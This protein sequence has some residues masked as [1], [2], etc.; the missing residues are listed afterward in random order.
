MANPTG[1]V[2]TDSMNTTQAHHN[3]S[4]SR[5]SDSLSYRK[6][7]TARFGEY[8][9]SFEME[10]VPTDRISLNSSDKMDSM[11]LKAP[12]K[13]TIR[14]IKESFS[15][16]NMA[17]L[18]QNWDR[19]YTQPSNG[20]DVP[21]DANCVLGN[22]PRNNQRFWL[23][24]YN[25]VNGAINALTSSSTLAD[26]AALL[27]GVF[28]CLF[29]G[30]YIYSYG[31]LPHLM[32]YKI[33][34]EWHYTRGGSSGFNGM[35][36]DAW[37][38]EVIR[39]FV[40]GR[41]LQFTL[42]EPV[43]SSFRSYLINASAS[44]EP[45]T[46][47]YL[48][49][50]RFFIEKMRE[51]P[52][53]YISDVRLNN[54]TTLEQYISVVQKQIDLTET[55][56]LFGT[57]CVFFYDPDAREDTGDITGMS[58]NN[59]NISRILAYQLVCAHY[60]SNSSIDFIYSAEL[61][62]QYVHTF[63][64]NQYATPSSSVERSFVWNGMNCPYDY[65]SEHY[66][67]RSLYMKLSALDYLSPS[68][69]SQPSFADFTDTSSSNYVA[70]MNRLA[71]Y[72]AIF[73]FRKSLRFGDYFVGSR[74]RPLAPINTDVSVNNNLVSV[75]D[76]TRNIQAQRFANA[77]IRSRQKIEEYVKSMFGNS[78]AP[79][80]HNPFFLSRETEVIF[81]DEVQNTG[82]A[83]AQNAVSRTALWASQ[84]NR[85]TFTFENDDAHP[86][87]YLQIVSFDV[88]RSYTRSVDRQF[89]NADRYD[90]FNPDFQYIGDQ[91][92]YGIELGYPLGSSLPYVFGYQSRDMEYKQR[93]DVAS[94]GFVENLP[95][96]LLTDRTRD[97]I[98]IAQLDPDF[99]RSFSC[100]LD[101]FY[102]SLTGYSLGSYFH[103]AIITDNNV[104]AVRP[105]A[106]DPQILE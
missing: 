29:L 68:S 54:S 46:G 61:Y 71:C 39:I 48:N 101:E 49:T 19:I 92:V 65:L 52:T 88:K 38:N 57:D 4:R 12:F 100:E 10:G 58:Q 24:F 67:A 30:E 73:G 50:L 22:F 91:P 15:V 72:S 102:L 83:Q 3:R 16:P 17:I 99:I 74:P 32:G 11:S 42:I 85:F 9:P 103:F 1:V 97:H 98:S 55:A 84:P 31:S 35:S 104:D 18:P 59:F 81:G 28:R 80:Y 79:D 64:K 23:A 94:G 93:F 6:S 69:I 21:I 77:V 7:Y 105:M 51:N 36:Y 45:R 70:M 13:G 63:F 86:C 90:M 26:V 43:G 40:T 53:C 41:L 96:W 2:Q 62:R 47:N 8:V 37:M 95:G 60:Y 56:P 66:I 25:G 82:A 33:A 78:P 106:V 44:G 27:T 34:D 89:L 20:D 76:I 87:I 14:K 5:F 75:I